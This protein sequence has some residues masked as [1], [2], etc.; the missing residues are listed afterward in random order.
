MQWSTEYQ[1]L[2]SSNG[3]DGALSWLG[4]LNVNKQG[5]YCSFKYVILKENNYI[6]IF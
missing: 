1:A 3:T 6:V 5:C 2:F 4:T